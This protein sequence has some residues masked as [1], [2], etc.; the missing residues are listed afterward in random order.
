MNAS[1]TQPPP[2]LRRA[3]PADGAISVLVRP[4]TGLARP[5][6]AVSRMTAHRR[7]RSTGPADPAI[8]PAPSRA[9]RAWLS[10]LA[11]LRIRIRSSDGVAP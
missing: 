11:Q 5:W 4:R 3:A 8:P 1:R 2:P 9:P 6:R 10:S 7:L